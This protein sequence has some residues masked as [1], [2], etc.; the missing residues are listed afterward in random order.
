MH[1]IGIAK[2]GNQ[3]RSIKFTTHSY[4][5]KV[6]LQ[7]KQNKKNDNRKNKKNPKHKSQVQL[8]VQRDLYPKI[9]LTCLE[10]PMR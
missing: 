1:P 9:E 7:H 5:E 3:A 8:N 10:K 4:K 6:F 2:N